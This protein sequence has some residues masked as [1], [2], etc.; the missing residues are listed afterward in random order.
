MCEE[1]L[2]ARRHLLGDVAGKD[3]DDQHAEKANPRHGQESMRLS[4]HSNLRSLYRLVTLHQGTRD[5]LSLARN[6]GGLLTLATSGS[7]PADALPDEEAD[8]R[9]D[10]GNDD[11]ADNIMG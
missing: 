7:S 6:I 1:A 4:F 11:L 2:I 8:D 5:S 3:A 10:G 9:A